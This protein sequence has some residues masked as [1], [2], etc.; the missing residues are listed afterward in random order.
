MTSVNRAG[1]KSLRAQGGIVRTLKT[2]MTA[3]GLAASAA[4]VAG[5]FCVVVTGLG[6]DCKYYDEGS[7]AQA[8]MERHG[9]CVDRSTGLATGF[10]RGARYCLVGAGDN[11]CEYYDAASCAKAAQ[12]HGGTC[13]QRPRSGT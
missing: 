9:A 8:A 13:V 5:P 1:A 4:C 6:Q 2:L 10:N 12:D 3:V 11:R 7:C